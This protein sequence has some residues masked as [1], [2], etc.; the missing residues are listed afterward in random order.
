MDTQELGRFAKEQRREAGLSQHDVALL[1]DVPE[2]CV[3]AFE[4]SKGSVHLDKAIS[5]LFVVGFDP[6]RRRDL[7][8]VLAYRCRLWGA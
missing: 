8:H 4:S 1:A 5:I 2:R 6:R 3:R 7:T